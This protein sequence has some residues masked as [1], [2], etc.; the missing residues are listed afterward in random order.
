MQ[1]MLHKVSNYSII[2]TLVWPPIEVK[3]LNSQ[4][5]ETTLYIGN[6]LQDPLVAY[7]APLKWNNDNT[8]IISGVGLHI[9]VQCGPMQ[10]NGHHR[11]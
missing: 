7:T 8:D 10:R 1:E 3:S 11:A 6:K 9:C 4:G 2:E 5:S